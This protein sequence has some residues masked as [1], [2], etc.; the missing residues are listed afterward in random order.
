MKDS[1]SEMSSQIIHLKDRGDFRN[2]SR[3]LATEI[4]SVCGAAFVFF[5][6]TPVIERPTRPLARSNPLRLPL[7]P[8]KSRLH[9]GGETLNGGQMV[10]PKRIF[11][12]LCRSRRDATATGGVF[13]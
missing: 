10:G 12:R 2:S 9:V 5:A 8:V 13:T 7:Q 4:I 3:I 6:V 11:R 1:N